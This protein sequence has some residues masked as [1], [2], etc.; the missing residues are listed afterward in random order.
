M[1]R[2]LIIEDEYRDDICHVEKRDVDGDIADDIAQIRFEGKYAAEYA[3]EY[4]NWKNCQMKL[5]NKS[6]PEKPRNMKLAS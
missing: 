5:K 3:Q 4:A 1:Y 6:G 2:F